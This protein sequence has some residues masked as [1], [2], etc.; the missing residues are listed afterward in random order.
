MHSVHWACRSPATVP[1]RPG[2][3][4]P[5]GHG[6]ICAGG[7]TC[8][9]MARGGSPA[10]NRRPGCARVHTHATGHRRARRGPK[11]RPWTD[12]IEV[13]TGRSARRWRAEWRWQRRPATGWPWEGVHGAHPWPLTHLPDIVQGTRSQRGGWMAEKRS[14]PARST[15]P[16]LNSGKDVDPS[17]R[18]A[19]PR[20]GEA[21]GPTHG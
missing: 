1:N 3:V 5:M 12:H 6:F 4:R 13:H 18:G 14:S 8:R 7:D 15:A 11:C 21:P 2:T 19:A 16:E 10:A 9:G 20:S 17:G